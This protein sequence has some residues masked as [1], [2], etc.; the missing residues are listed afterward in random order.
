MAS[1]TQPLC[2]W[3]IY[4]FHCAKY[5]QMWQSFLRIDHLVQTTDAGRAELDVISSNKNPRNGPKK[6]YKMWASRTNARKYEICMHQLLP[7]FFHFHVYVLRR[8]TYGEKFC[9]KE[10]FFEAAA[11]AAIYANEG[12]Y[13]RPRHN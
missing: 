1:S 7:I 9:K 2:H 10:G 6:V 8:Q 11:I 3:T 4:A 5:M 12:L 13:I